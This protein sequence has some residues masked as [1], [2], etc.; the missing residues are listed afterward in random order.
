MRNRKL[1]L[2]FLF[3][4]PGAL[5]ALDVKVRVEDKR[6]GKPVADAQIIVLETKEKF[7]AD[8]TGE[9]LVRVPSRGFVTIRAISP[10]G[11]IVQPR[12][13]ISGP[14]Q[15]VTIFLGI[16]EVREVQRPVQPQQVN[17]E[18]G[19]T[20]AGQ[21]ER[22]KVSR[23][24]VRIDEVKRIPGQFGEA[25]RGLETLP[26][27]NAPPFGNGDIAVRGANTNANTY[28]VDDLPI[29]YAFHFAGL[30]SVLHNDLIKSIDLYT[31]AYPVVYGNA[32]GGVVAIDT[33]DNVEKFGG[34]ATFSLWAAQALFKGVLGDGAGYWVASGRISYL[35]QTLR[36]YIPSGTTLIPRYWDEQ[37][38]AMYRLSPTQKLYFCVLGSK[39]E[40][41]AKIENKPS[42]DPTSEFDPRLVGAQVAFDQ[43]FHTEAVRHVWTPG[44]RVSNELTAYYTNNIR[45]IDGQLGLIRA[46]QIQQDGYAALK[47]AFTW[48]IFKDHITFDAGFEARKFE[49]RNNGQTTQ[50]VNPNNPSPDP[51]KT[52]NPDYVNVPV[53]D[54]QITG[55]DTGYAMLTLKAWGFEAK[56]GVRVD[57]FGLNRERVVD[58]RGVVSYSFPTK[59]TISGGAGVYHRVPDAG[60]Y[61]TSSGNPDLRLER[62]EHYGGGIEQ[63][64]DSWTF[65]GE[66][67]RH[68]YTDI[69]VSDPYATTPVRLNQDPFY[70]YTTPFNY[71]AP[72]Y[73][74]NDGTGFSE[75]WEIYIKKVKPDNQNGLYGW[76]SYTWSRTLR[77]THQHIITD[78]EKRILMSADESR[79]V[80]QYDN[81][82]DHYADFDRTHIVN[83]VLGWKISREW[84]VGAKWKYMTSQ[85]YT[86]IVK[87][88]GG[89]QIQNG[90]YVFNPV[91]STEL[92]S[93]RLKPYHRLDV[94][95]DRFMNYG[96][97]FGNVFV[98]MLNVYLRDNPVNLDWNQSRPISR[99]NPSIQNDFGTLETSTGDGRRVKFPLINFGLEVQF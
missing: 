39:D 10:S 49:Y 19:I 94:R 43:A 72:L 98:E 59:T 58:P 78:D 3:L 85:P 20:V 44:S 35:D 67:Y 80:H 15:V 57:Y 82:K 75:G 6:T 74:S 37:F 38:K 86:P 53:R 2:L 90:R 55:Y 65:K 7:F 61:S 76:L 32:T 69:V 13:E 11:E 84:Q 70:R 40:F 79:I 12:I 22:Q 54:V 25:L 47:D 92:E 87:D 68:Y 4:L 27:V 77:N 14:N 28:L 63:V 48:D 46:K 96:W 56:P 9:A 42:W 16:E 8:E 89:R 33:I 51:Y 45:Y 26:G 60:T 34:H 81:T 83:V 73:Y 31:G 95:I 71:N 88:D 91:Y 30:N 23:Y 36:P 93:G 18:E 99:T 1:F 64:V 52:T 66:V 21:R 17:K 50:L 24:Q 41:I 5:L 29:G 62:A 97:G